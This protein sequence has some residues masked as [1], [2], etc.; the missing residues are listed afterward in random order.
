MG[1][2]AT[3]ARL[4]PEELDR[5][6]AEELVA[7]TPGIH[8]D[9]ARW[10]EVSK[11]GTARRDD[12]LKLFE[13]MQVDAEDRLDVADDL[14]D[15]DEDFA[16]DGTGLE[17]SHG[18]NCPGTFSTD[19]DGDSDGPAIEYPDDGFAVVGTPLKPS[20]QVKLAGRKRPH[21]AK[22]VESETFAADGEAFDAVDAAAPGAF[23]EDEDDGVGGEGELCFDLGIEGKRI[24]S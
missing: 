19:D 4:L 13:E 23:D 24:G 14:A 15:G 7:S 11:G 8:W 5:A 18:A 1:A 2:G 10:V 3:S 16:V 17:A 12:L 22:D 20:G 9:D 6:M 21:E